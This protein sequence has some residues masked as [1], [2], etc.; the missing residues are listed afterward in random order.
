[1]INAS[2]SL[3]NYFNK[4]IREE[5]QEIEIKI[6][7]SGKTYTITDDDLVASSVKIIKKSVSGASFDIGE[8]YVDSATFT[9]NKNINNYKSLTG[10]KVTIRIKV[11]NTD[12]NISESVLLGTFRI[13]QDGIKRTNTLLQVTADS[14]ISKFD[15]SR[16]RATFTG[17]LYDLITDSCSK[18]KVTFG[19][20]ESAFRALSPN[21]AKTYEIK[22][23]S[24]LKT[25]RDVIMYV[26]Q[27][28]GGFA[29]TTPSGE[30]I[31]KNYT[32]RNDICNVNDNVIINYSIGDEVYNLS[33]LGMSV[34]ENDVYLYRAGEDDDSPYF[35]NLDSNPI[36]ENCTDEE[37]TEIVGNIWGKLIELNLNNFSFDFNGNP[38]IEVG[39]I[40]S[41]P[42]RSLETYVASCEWVYHGKEK[43]SCVSVDK[44]KRI[45]TQKE[46][47]NENKPKDSSKDDRV[48]DLIKNTTTDTRKV[49]KTVTET[50]TIRNNSDLGQL[51]NYTDYKNITI[52]TEGKQIS[53]VLPSGETTTDKVSNVELFLIFYYPSLFLNI[54]D[55]INRIP[56]TTNDNDIITL[57]FKDIKGYVFLGYASNSPSYGFRIFNIKPYTGSKSYSI[58]DYDMTQVI[59]NV[60]MSVNYFDSLSDS[61]FYETDAFGNLINDIPNFNVSTSGRTVYTNLDGSIDRTEDYGIDASFNFKFNNVLDANG[62]NYESIENNILNIKYKDLKYIRDSLGNNIFD[63]NKFGDTTEFYKNLITYSDSYYNRTKSKYI[64][65]FDNT[66]SKG[67]TLFSYCDIEQNVDTQNKYDNYNYKDYFDIDITYKEEVEESYTTTIEGTSDKINENAEKT[68]KNKDEIE[69]LKVDVK[70]NKTNIDKLKQQVKSVTNK[71]GAMSNSLGAAKTDIAKLDIRVTNLENSGSSDSGMTDEQ[72]QQLEQNTTDIRNLKTNVS[73]N[74]QNIS[75]NKTNI[76]NLTT[77]VSNL[78]NSGGSGSGITETERQQIQTNKTDIANLTTRVSNLENSGG[79]GSGIT[80]IERQQIQTNKTNIENLNLTVSGNTTSI[81]DILR[82]LAQLEQG[83]GGEDTG[84]ALKFIKLELIFKENDNASSCAKNDYDFTKYFINDSYYFSDDGYTY[85]RLKATLNKTGTKQTFRETSRTDGT[86]YYIIGVADTRDLDSGTVRFNSRSIL[87]LDCISKL[88]DTQIISPQIKVVQYTKLSAKSNNRD[89]KNETTGQTVYKEGG[90][91]IGDIISVP[92]TVNYGFKALTINNKPEELNKYWYAITTSSSNKMGVITN[93]K[94][95]DAEPNVST[96]ITFTYDDSLANK[97]V[98]VHITDGQYTAYANYLYIKKLT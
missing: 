82:R 18:C 72:K 54:S 38:L 62:I 71:V 73:K 25:H 9:I 7:K 53:T 43:I 79:S 30:L 32:S 36:M 74:T 48:D 29:T 57:N 80:E 88:D 2:N 10:A 94:E 42:E 68:D 39:D 44:N 22:K 78:E 15:K 66:S 52:Y 41:I 70:K 16:K 45:E 49:K 96:N 27:L 91:H 60:N 19:M 50:L 1:M 6:S 23:D 46:K 4:N 40:I 64:D 26:A 56:S 31:F 75:T 95:L 67:G 85:Y 77:R 51:I 34:K 76:D 11:N 14:Y 12:L 84:E 81:E 86:Q 8:C 21:V 20:S 3:Y 83:G 90:A 5:G 65:S 17:D 58:M 47:Q 37:I 92:L 61:I 33:G 93:W 59:Q 69:T 98:Y 24:S 97:N 87:Y 13:L 28:I 63:T 55:I 35:L 89:W